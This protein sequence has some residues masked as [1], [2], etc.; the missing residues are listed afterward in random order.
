LEGG[1]GRL[2]DKDP[3]TAK[4]YFQLALAAQPDSI[5]A[6]RSLATACALTGD[7]K[8]AFQALRREKAKTHDHAGFAAWVAAEPAFTRFRNDRELQTLLDHH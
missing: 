2:A 4:D 5:W 8:S 3:L 1:L 6:L 7:R